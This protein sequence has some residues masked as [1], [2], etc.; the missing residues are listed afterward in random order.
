MT[1]GNGAGG[2]VGPVSAANSLVGT[3]AF[4]NVGFDPAIVLPNGHYV[5][6]NRDWHD[7]GGTNSGAVTWGNGLT[8]VS[9]AITPANSLVG[10]GFHGIGVLNNGIVVLPGSDYLVSNPQWSAANNLP[11]VGAVT[12]SSGTGGTVGSVSAANSLTGTHPN[13]R[14]GSGGV[15]GLT[16]GQYA[17][18][19][20]DWDNGPSAD[21]GAVTWLVGGPASVSGVVSAANSLTGTTPG[22]QVGIGNAA[23][24]VG[25][26]ALATGHYAVGSPYWNNGAA[27]HAGA[28]TWLNGTLPT[29]GTVSAANSLVGTTADDQVGI[30]LLALPGGNYLADNPYWSNGAAAMAGAVTWLPGNAPTSGVVSAANSL[31]GTTTNDMVG[32]YSFRL[33]PTGDYLIGSDFW[34]APGAP[35]AGAV[36]WGSG[37]TGVR[38]PVSAANSLV[39]V[40][41]NDL[42]F[43]VVVPQVDGNYLLWSRY[44]DNETTADAGAVTL[45]RGAAGPVGRVSG[46]TSAIGA[47]AQQGDKLAVAYYLPT[48]QLLTGLPSENRVLRGISGP[49]PA[50]TGAAVQ[51]VGAG[52]TVASLAA[53]GTAVQWYAA[54]TGGAALPAST[55]LANGSTYYASQTLNGCES[56]ARLAVTVSAPL[57]VQL[58]AFTAQAAGP[59]AVALA[60]TTAS[61]LN[62]AYFEVERSLDGVG[63]Q[64]VGEVAA[65]GSS[66]SV[67]RY[68]YRDDNAPT[69]LLYYRLRQVDLDG[70]SAYSLVRTVT[71]TGAGNLSLYPN[72]APG[73][74]ATLAG[75]VPGA[76]VQVLDALGRRVAAATADATGTA[77]LGGLAPGLYLVRAGSS[78]VRLAVE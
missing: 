3:T 14:I 59:A 50:P 41:T 12:W 1:W 22:D 76:A 65:A 6:H 49:P 44:W 9:G 68:A 46:C 8:G 20:P 13:D 11:Q 52:A 30:L 37:A 61:E 39:G 33:L 32:L 63:Y 2:T 17:V 31:V 24:G 69:G 53:T 64:K 54:A 67:R 77:R 28:I 5:L 34:N 57:P 15:V 19:S 29:S 66:L 38:G 35:R 36:T 70:L 40:R 71:L 78:S 23:G 42:S 4:D 16:G 58:T 43:T 62:S 75:A 7:G 74:A 10:T 73:G 27:T 18:S 72:P 45:G 56:V 26:V 47:V 48:K 51:S 55:P 21:V 25:L 60:W